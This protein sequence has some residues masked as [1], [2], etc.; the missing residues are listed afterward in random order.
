MTNVK[1]ALFSNL[2]KLECIFLDKKP[3]KIIAMIS[4]GSATEPSTF[5]RKR[6]RT[7]A[8]IDVVET[9]FYILHTFQPFEMCVVL[10]AFGE[11]S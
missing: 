2:T 11:F 5:E 6:M 9:K 4:F 8:D 7:C 1:K 3:I 10:I